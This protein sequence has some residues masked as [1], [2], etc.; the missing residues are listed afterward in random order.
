MKNKLFKNLNVS[1]RLPIYNVLKF[2]FLGASV[3]FSK[4]AFMF[5]FSTIDKSD[6]KGVADI[7]FIN[8]N[9]ALFISLFSTLVLIPLAQYK[10]YNKTGIV[11]FLI[12]SCLTSFFWTQLYGYSIEVTILMIAVLL[13]N[14]AYE[15]SRRLLYINKEKLVIKLDI[16]VTGIYFLLLLISI[17]FGLNIYTYLILSSLTIFGFSVFISLKI[18]SEAFKTVSLKKYLSL[19][20]SGVGQSLLLFIS[21]NFIFQ[22]ISASGSERI[23]TKV[24]IIRIW[25]A[26]VGLLL[27]GLDFVF[28]R[29]KYTGKIPES[30]LFVAILLGGLSFL[31]INDETLIYFLAFI[32]I[33]PFQ[34]WLRETQIRMRQIEKHRNIWTINVIFT[35]LSVL[36]SYLMVANTSWQYWSWYIII[37]Y[38][39]LFI[40]WKIGKH[41]G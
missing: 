25:T 38:I 18:D 11:S 29:D 32:F 19:N 24:N 30:V 22:L 14:I 12:I 16:I 35:L 6:Q 26:P 9:N 20:H 39:I 10:F 2:S 17:V 40:G 41:R 34:F 4:F 37:V 21:G 8:G 28:S 3:S 15:T 7:V 1:N 31:V 27:N 36:L 23:F 13:A 33:V 5:Y